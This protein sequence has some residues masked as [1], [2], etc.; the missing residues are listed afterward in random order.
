[1]SQREFKREAWQNLNGVVDANHGEQSE[2]KRRLWFRGFGLR[3]SVKGGD[4]HD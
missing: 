2:P 3:R 1:M 4:E